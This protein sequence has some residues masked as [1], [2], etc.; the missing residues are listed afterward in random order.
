MNFMLKFVSR[1]ITFP[2]TISIPIFKITFPGFL[3]LFIF[4]DTC[5]FAAA[6]I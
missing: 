2:Q 6:T 3:N 1:N 4:S 5:Y